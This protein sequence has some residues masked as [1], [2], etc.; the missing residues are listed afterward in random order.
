MTCV[1]ATIGNIII[2]NVNKY[3]RISYLK[4]N[5]TFTT[6]AKQAA[7]FYFLKCNDQQILNNDPVTINL[8]SKTLSLSTDLIPTLQNRSNN[9]FIISNGTDNLEL[10]NY[11]SPILILSGDD[12][13]KALKCDWKVENGYPKSSAEL[14]CEPFDNQDLESYQ[15]HLELAEQDRYYQLDAGKLFSQFFNEN[16]NVIV[17]V[18]LCIILLLCLTIK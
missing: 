18:M 6:D 13:T 9:N 12:V 8:S 11:N 10:I 2:K 7:K 16:V 4:S 17:V 1:Q 15:F 3:N 5:L 14:C